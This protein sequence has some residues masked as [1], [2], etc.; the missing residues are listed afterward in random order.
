MPK[1]FGSI[2]VVMQK[3]NLKLIAELLL[4]IKGVKTVLDLGSGR[5][6]A[7]NFFAKNGC[8]VTA[9]DLKDNVEFNNP[10]VDWR[11]VKVE[12]FIGLPENHNKKWDLIFSQNLLQFLNKEWVY[13]KLLPWM[14]DHLEA[15]G[16]IAIKTFYQEPEPAF[17]RSCLSLYGAED[18]LSKFAD[19]QIILQGQKEIVNFDMNKVSRN[20][21]ITNLII[22]KPL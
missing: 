1:C 12:D 15:G 19:F 13:A 17:S 20:F 14:K 5:G 21:F 8:G 4:L 16:I 18:L 6:R 22:Q 3:E 10:S 2:E 11:F 9:V 7:A